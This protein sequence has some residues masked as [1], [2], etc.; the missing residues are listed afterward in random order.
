VGLLLN[1]GAAIDAEDTDG[2]T[3]LWWAVSYSQ[4]EVAKLLR[5]KG[6]H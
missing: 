5:E 2:H 6:A 3:A 4:T 1:R